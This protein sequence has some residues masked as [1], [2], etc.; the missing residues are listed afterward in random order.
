[1]LARMGSGA[2][3]WHRRY[4]PSMAVQLILVVS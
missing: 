1:M 4:K 3:P 2:A